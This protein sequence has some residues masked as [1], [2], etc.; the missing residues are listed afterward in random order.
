LILDILEDG[1]EYRMIGEESIHKI[2][3]GSKLYL[4]CPVLQLNSR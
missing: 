4:E 1:V 2:S 3:V